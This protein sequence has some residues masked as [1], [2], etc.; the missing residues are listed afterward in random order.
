MDRKLAVVDGH[1]PEAFDAI[2]E[3]AGGEDG[4]GEEE[5]SGNPLEEDVNAEVSWERDSWSADY[6]G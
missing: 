3:E 6:C 4:S 2:E 1:D 5:V